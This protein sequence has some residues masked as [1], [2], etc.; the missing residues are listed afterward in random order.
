MTRSRHHFSDCNLF[1]P[2]S[3]SSF[4]RLA[5]L[6][7]AFSGANL[8]Y[9]NRWHL[10]LVLKSL[11]WMIILQWEGKVWRCCHT[12]NIFRDP[13]TTGGPICLTAGW[14]ET[15]QTNKAPTVWLRHFF[16]GKRPE[17]ANALM[18]HLW[19]WSCCCCHLSLFVT[20]KGTYS[21]AFFS[22]CHFSHC[23]EGIQFS[24]FYFVGL[25]LFYLF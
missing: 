13:N 3:G 20:L 6:K 16:F 8:W 2:T 10:L 4:H 25:V 24:F 12:V 23:F 19:D 11:K 5:V 22:F 14:V 9:G 17:L 15:E 7:L 18:Q 1:K 21:N